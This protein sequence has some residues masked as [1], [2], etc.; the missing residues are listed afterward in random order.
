M[1]VKLSVVI[2]TFNEERNIE[3]CLNS[4]KSFA[5]DIV[6]V[7]SF[8]TDQTAEICQ[9]HGARF[10]THSFAGHIEQKNWA[11]SQAKYP[12]ILSLDADEAPDEALCTAI[13]NVKKNWICDGYTMN[14]L[15]NYCGKWIRHSSW[16][17]DVKLRLWD[18]TRGRWAGI[19]PHDRFELVPGT[20]TAH[21]KGNIL[22]YSYYS[23]S[24]HVAQANRFSEIAAKAYHQQGKK[25]PMIKVLL[26]PIAR[27]IKMYL[28][29][30]G[31]LDG[32]EGFIIARIASFEVFLK[33]TRLRRI[34]SSQ[35]NNNSAIV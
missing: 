3:R 30:A 17:P 8:S 11:I 9:R 2:I 15:T 28:L 27:F 7:D 35:K 19:N 26:S 16:Y 20:T 1:E 21:L 4:V 13:S 10:I 5:D 25:A 29:H 22:H 6:V 18:S 12:H 33:Y 14:R 32:T 34:I 24:E 23:I 31:F